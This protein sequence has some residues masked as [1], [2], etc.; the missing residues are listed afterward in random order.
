MKLAGSSLSM[1]S[2]QIGG[3]RVIAIKE[4]DFQKLLAL[5]RIGEDV[6]KEKVLPDCCQRCA[7]KDCSS[8]GCPACPY[9][10][11]KPW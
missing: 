5:A 9:C 4:T 10:G 11:M 8:D 2:F 1:G 3:T 6:W 7:F